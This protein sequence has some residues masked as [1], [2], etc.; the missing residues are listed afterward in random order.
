MGSA[1]SGLARRSV[2]V[3]TESLTIPTVVPI[4]SGSASSGSRLLSL[5]RDALLGALE[6][7]ER[8][9]LAGRAPRHE[10][11]ADD[12]DLARPRTELTL[13]DV[14]AVA[15]APIRLRKS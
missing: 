9:D 7:G 10:S 2:G 14:T 1:S 5:P 12:L 13:V 11:V 15:I 3:A 6:L 8:G 4:A